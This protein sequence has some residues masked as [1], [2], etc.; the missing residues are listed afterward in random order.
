MKKLIPILIVL[1]SITLKINAQCKTDN[2]IIVSQHIHTVLESGQKYSVSVTFKN[3]GES[4][5]QKEK[6]WILYTDPRM[7]AAASNPWVTDKI[8][9]KKNVRPG[10]SYTFNF[11]ITAPNEP[12]TYFFSWLMCSE[13]GSFGSGSELKE[14]KVN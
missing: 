14:V 6:Y 11:Y 4:T 10:K 7:N 5:W 3:T 13:S 12:G 2:A 9:I 8:K 1:L